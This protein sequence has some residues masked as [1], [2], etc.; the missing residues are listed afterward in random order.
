[1]S[2]AKAMRDAVHELMD[3][4]E[5]Q[6]ARNIG[7]IDQTLKVAAYAVSLKGALGALPE[8]R[9]QDLLPPSLVFTVQIADR[10]GRV[11]ASS[12]PAPARSIAGQDYF[13]SQVARADETTY[14]GIPLPDQP[15]GTPLLHF[16]RRLQD[17][18]GNFDGVVMVQ[19]DPGYFTSSDEKTRQGERG[20]LAIFGA[21]N[22]PRALRV[23]AREGWQGPAP[24]L[25][26]FRAQPA[27]DGVDRETIVQPSLGGRLTVVVGLARGEQMA[28][29]MQNRKT[30][31]LLALIA[32]AVLLLFAGMG[33]AWSWQRAKEQRCGN[34]GPEQA[35]VARHEL[36]RRAAERPQQRPVRQAAAGGRRPRRV[37]GRVGKRS[38]GGA[39]QR[40]ASAGGGRGRRRGGDRARHYRAQADRNTDTEHGAARC[41]DRFAQPQP[42]HAATGTGRQ[43]RAGRWP[44][45]AGVFERPGRLQA[46]Q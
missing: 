1:M 30:N 12:P 5:A 45:G 31:I 42:D 2:A 36:D 21:D 39:R 27:W 46:G 29:F 19:V 41:A 11:I 13:T 4:Y 17:G 14:V 25:E 40:G 37:R 8:L 28:P 22:Q 43:R 3:T 15:G 33:W 26:R 44:C 38:R 24:S 6:V 32:S 18:A 10:D 34:D 9:R 16:T 35:A 23:G 7:A 20:L